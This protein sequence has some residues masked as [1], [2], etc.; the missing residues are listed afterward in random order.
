ML[1]TKILYINSPKYDVITALHIEGLLG[2]T[3]L[4]VRFTSLGNYATSDKVL[5]K[6]DAI[7]YGNEEADILILGSRYVDHSTKSSQIN[8]DTAY[9]IR[10]QKDD[11]DTF[12]QIKRKD[13]LRV[14]M[15]GGDESALGVRLG[16][17]YRYNLIF[18]RELYLTDWT[19]AAL[20]YSVFPGS[21]GLWSPLRAH[22]LVPFP[23]YHS[24]GNPARFP[25]QARN[26][27][28]NIAWYPGRKRVK[29]FPIGI[30]QRLKG[31]YNDSP[32][33]E[34]C[35]MMRVSVSDRAR[36]FDLL[37]KKQYPRMFLDCYKTSS[38]T[39]SP[40][41]DDIEW[42]IERGASHPDA[43]KIGGSGFAQNNAYQAQ[44]NNS[45]ATICLPGGG[46]DTLRFWEILGQGSLLISKRIAI[47][48]PSP[49]QEGVH[50][51]AFDTIDEFENILDW[52]YEN[53]DEVDHIRRQG[54]EFAL[55][56]HSSLARAD[57]FLRTVEGYRGRS[58]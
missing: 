26:M 48:M 41:P 47:Q 23:Y 27:V 54:H 28:R 50:Y 7:N 46:Y 31:E 42:M 1:P 55:K 39:L 56:E 22:K 32:D 30:E 43:V 51:L 4:Q 5:N 53:P 9:L 35:C 11:I 38:V 18:K 2:I 15:E 16:E 12:W 17:F 14:R 57:Y 34:L 40:R 8:A 44:L 24:M 25:V 13:I 33:Y 37:K 10:H 58:L 45:R 36:L 29:S 49:L 3:G 21:A 52:I 20:R 19:L 6:Q